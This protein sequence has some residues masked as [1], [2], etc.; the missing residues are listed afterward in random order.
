VS[1]RGSTGSARGCFTP[2]KLEKA[3][4]AHSRWRPHGTCCCAGGG[5]A[6][7]LSQRARSGVSRHAECAAPPPYWHWAP[8][9][10]HSAGRKSGSRPERGTPA[11]GGGEGSGSWSAGR[12]YGQ[13]K[14]EEGPTHELDLAGER[15]LVQLAFD[16]CARRCRERRSRSEVGW[17]R[18]SV[19]ARGWGAPRRA[20]P[21]RRGAPLAVAFDT[22]A[23]VVCGDRPLVIG[24]LE[25]ISVG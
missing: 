9:R 3:L 16:L 18:V 5:D 22:R 1:L 25:L 10:S 11:W 7:A 24:A 8:S 6:T 13:G 15:A 4:D 14:K 19:H 12:R 17:W 2:T 23:H 21:A 20:V